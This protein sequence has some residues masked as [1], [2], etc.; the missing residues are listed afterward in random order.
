[1]GWSLSKPVTEVTFTDLQELVGVPESDGLE[2]KRDAYPRNDEGTREMLRDITSFAN[3]TGAHLFLG[4]QQDG[5]GRASEIVGIPDAETEASRM[6]S[7]CLANVE[8]RILGLNAHPVPVSSDRGVVVCYIPRSTRAPHMIRF[9]GL[10]QCWKRH[11]AQKAPMSIEEIREACLRTHEIRRSL[12]DFLAE[13]REKVLAQT[14]DSPWLWLT[15]TPLLVKD[16]VRNAA[17]RELMRRPPY[18]RA[19]GAWGVACDAEPRPT[20]YGL[21][22][23]VPNSRRLDVFRNGHVEFR[24]PVDRDVFCQEQFQGRDGEVH[25]IM[26]PYA[27]AEYPLSFAHFAAAFADRAG[28]MEPMVL[29]LSVL[30]AKGL[31]LRAGVPETYHYALRE[32]H[33]LPTWQDGQHLELPAMLFS[34]PLDPRRAAKMLADRMWNAFGYEG[35]PVLG[36]DGQLVL[37]K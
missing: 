20:L 4:I 18:E 6:L 15:A 26:Y 12:E 7:S 13:R 34:Y 35:C 9:K 19:V 29:A 10:Y 21:A 22:V 28:I 37:A 8:E 32:F 17:I 23:E 33:S 11:G 24:V 5:E 2:F 16:D 3:A 1:L 25:L 36:D 30:S 27:L 31:A 14:G